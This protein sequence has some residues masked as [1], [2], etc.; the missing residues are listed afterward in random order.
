MSAPPKVTLASS[1]W[2]PGR[3]TTWGSRLAITVQIQDGVA[4]LVLDV[5]RGSVRFRGV[6]RSVILRAEDGSPIPSTE[7][8]GASALDPKVW[9]RIYRADAKR[10]AL[11]D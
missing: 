8:V 9:Q 2:T 10:R 4:N 5:D 11:Y 1:D 6:E 7:H 3:L